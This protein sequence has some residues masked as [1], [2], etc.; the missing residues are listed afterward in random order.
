MA[1]NDR[2]FAPPLQ[3]AVFLRARG[4][5]DKGRSGG[6]V[7]PQLVDLPTGAILFRLYQDEH[8]PFG[9]W[10]MTPHELSVISSYFGRSGPAFATGR[11]TGEGIL[12]GT[13][14]VRSHWSGLRWFMVVRLA[15]SLKAYHGEGD[16]APNES[17]TH[18]Q[19]TVRIIDQRNRQRS[20]RQIFIPDPFKYQ[21]AF[22]VVR[23]GATD[24]GLLTALQ[25]FGSHALS[26]E[27]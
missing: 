3:S 17:Q 27:H 5:T 19:K 16:H 8:K 20:A 23:D 2:Y 4:W 7:S 24:T 6:I 14:A 21:H 25:Q 22:S 13:F 26:F 11:A 1:C 10:W 18:V 15:M 12:H 9:D